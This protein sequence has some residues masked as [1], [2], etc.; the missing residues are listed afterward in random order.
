MN[1]KLLIPLF[2]LGIC[3]AF[4]QTKVSGYVFDEFNEPVSFATI[5]FQGSTQGTIT[6]ENGKF[7][8]ESKETWKALVVSF[9]GYET[10]NIPLDKKVN[11][12]LKFILK[13]EAA[14]LDAVVIVSGKQSKKNN[15]A[16]DLLR[17]IWANKRSNGL[18]QFK[19]YEYDKYEKI[20][21]DLN[22]ID[23]ALIKSKLFRGMEFVF[24]E[25]DTSSVTGKTYLPIFINEAVSK[26]YGNNVINKTK[27]DLQGNKNSGFSNN[28][29][30]IDFVD[31]LYTDFNVY[32]NYL[33]FFDKS[34]VSP[35]SKTGINTYNYVLSDSTFIGDKWCYN[36][37]Y[38][39]RRKNELTFKGDFWVADT[40]Y[41][42]KEINLQA[43]KSANINWVKE[44][45]I[46]QEFEVLNDSLF[47]V[48][49]DYMLSDFAFNKK[50][51]SRGVYGKRTTL[52]NNYKFDIEK[53]KKFYDKDVYNYDSDVYNRSDEFW[54]DN[55]LEKLNK[56]EKGVYKMLDTLKT[57]KKFKRL[58]NLGSILAS[59]YIEF[60]E[61][62]LDYG[63]V[64][65]TFGFNEV[66]GIRL[67]TGGRTYFGPNDLWRLEGF[68][69]YGF[70]DD[71]FKYGIS[72]KWLL[73]KKS[74]LIISGGNRR[75]VEQ[76]G[77][78]LTTSTDVLG[79]SLA[80]SSVVG[81][82]AN[83]KLTSI[84]L[85]SLAIEAEPWQNVI[86]RLGGNYRTLESA[87]PTFSLDYNTPT[88][89]ASE[90][91]QYE[92][93]VSVSYFPGRK[94]TG[95]GVERRIANDYFARLFAQATRGDK[96]IFNSDFD[97][98]KVQL[99]YTQPW[100]MGGFGRLFTTIEA[101]KTFGEVPLGLL[102][103]I[104]GNQTY[105]SIYN[106]F[107]QLDFY[108]F[109]SDT[110]ASFH[111]EHNFNGRF[112]SRI[113][114]LRKLNLREIISVRGV[115]GNISDE[116][117]ALSNVPSNPNNLQ[118][119]AP[120]NEPYYEYSLGIGNIFKVFRIDFNFRGNYKDKV[121]Y[122]DARKFGVTGSFG[123]YF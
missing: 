69:A 12:N 33:K 71:K 1:L 83:D 44:I 102:S 42:I 110:Y 9:I 14:Q 70:K 78:S 13:E 115:I 120:S 86:F 63:P 82:G 119:V 118:L 56:D 116:N 50:E 103:V 46:E 123:F 47:L 20:E 3:S 34:F 101:G 51:K 87:S 31:D 81:T 64:F 39:P 113:P 19:Q 10:L 4:S 52:Y 74:R 77:A 92:T 109:V 22:T 60:N 49:R 121:I 53:D 112:F 91:K 75:D 21:F 16:I 67:R 45:Y 105:F 66:E 68:L 48:T 25:V 54:D 7:Y 106:T 89:V 122:P 94:M 104:P 93:N 30:I 61:L 38:Y 55:R 18:K 80:S 85:T 84:N 111:F 32:D 37:I 17:K 72:G 27:E 117:L 15:P 43:S 96:N 97:Y 41:A 28:Q 11:Y 35:L 95:F 6:D 100:Q 65:S 5:I 79:R 73:H 76:T 99:S 26:V 114:F 36:I 88:D 98:T 23:S 40:T 29:V 108:E 90:I 59:G 2:F 62:P 58:Y 24:E 8:L 57:V 107:S